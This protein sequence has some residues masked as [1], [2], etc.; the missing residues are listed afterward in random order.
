MGQEQRALSRD[1]IFRAVKDQVGGSLGR[2]LAACLYWSQHTQ[3]NENGMPAVWKTGAELGKE[4]TGIIV[5]FI[6]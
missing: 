6:I 5:R 3:R 1:A 2:T 4:L